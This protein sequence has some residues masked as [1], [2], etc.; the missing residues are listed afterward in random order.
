MK[1]SFLMICLILAALLAQY[2]TL[3][4][5]EACGVAERADILFLVD[6]SW[7][8]GESNFQ[9]IRDFIYD[10]IRT[11][12]NAMVGKGGVRLGVVLY[13]DKPRISIDLTDYITIEEVLVAVRD[14]VFKGGDG[15]TGSAFSFLLETM[16]ITGA[17]RGDAAKV[18]VLITDGKSSDSVEEAARLLKDAGVTVFTVGI[19]N[20]DRKELRKLASDPAEEHMLY[21][22]DFHQLGS[23]SRKLSRRLCITASE[24][25]RPAKPRAKVEKIVKPRDLI[26][27]E[28]SHNSLRLTWTPAT[29]KVTGYQVL[30][31]SFSTPGQAAP[32]D[33]RLIVL[34]ASKSTVLVTEL[35][36]NTKYFFTVLTVYADVL[37]EPATVKGKTTSIPPVTN[38]RVIEEGL[39]SLRVAWTPPLGKLEGYK[40]YIPKSNKTGMTSEK[41][42]GSDVSSHLLD[43]L[44]EDKDYTISI[45]A[46]YPEGPSQPVSTTGKTLKLLPVK[47]IWLQNETTNTIQARWTQVRG[48]SGYRLTWVSSEGSVQ[49]VNLG[50]TYSYYMIQGLQPGTEYTITVNPIFG[51]TEGPIVT[52]KATTLSSSAV[53]ILKAT[54]ITINSAVVFWNSVPGATGYRMT[55]GPTPEF[56]GQDR[57]RQLALNSSTTAYHLQNL[58]HNTEYVISL[59]VLFGSVEGPGITITARTSPLGSVSNFKVTSYTS[60]SI[61]LSWSTVPAA[62]K[63]KIIWKP[64]GTG[65]ERETAK[66]LLL[67]SHLRAHHLENLL[68]NTR[69]AIGIRAVFGTTEGKVVTLTQ[70]TVGSLANLS[71]PVLTVTS[72]KPVTMRHQPMTSSQLTSP[73]TTSLGP[74]FTAAHTARVP[75]TSVPSAT[76]PGP[77]CSKFKADIAFLVDESSSIGQSNFLKVKEFLFRI[78]S[79][80]PKI[81]PEGTQIAVA[82]YSE[83]PR[84]E[85]HFNRYQDRNSVLKAI[86]RLRYAGGDTKTGRGIGYMLKEVF[87]ASKGMRP[88]VPHTLVLLTDGRSQD[89]VLPPAQVA[90][91]IGIRLITVGVSGADPQELK[92]ILLHRNLENLF[93]VSTFDDLPQIIR[94]LI[95]TICIGSQQENVVTQHN[96]LVDKEGEM[97]KSELLLKKK[98]E[99]P[100]SSPSSVPLVVHPPEGPCDLKCPKAQ[101]GEKGDRGPPGDASLAGLHMGG[102]YDPFSFATKGE[103]GERGLPGKDGIPGLPG[104]PGRTGS[105]GSPGLMGLPGIQGDH[106]PPGY[107][108]PPG[109]KG[110]RGEPGYVLGGVEVIPGQNGQPGPPGYKGQPGVPGVPGPPGLPGLPG[111]QGPPGLSVKGELG[112]PGIRGPRGKNGLKGEKGEPGE[113]GKAGLPGPIGLDGTPGASGSKGEKGE[114][115]VGVP[116]L[117]GLKGAEGNKGVTGPPGSQGQKGE[118]GMPGPEGPT[119]LRGKKGQDGVKGEKG[120]RGAAGMKGLQGIAGLPGP[121]GPKGDQGIQGFPG[122]PAMGVVGPTGKKGSRGD[123]GAVGPSGPKGESGKQGEKGEKGSPGFG[124]PGQLGLKGEPGERGNV[125]LSGKPGQKGEI[126]PKGNKGEPGE[127]GNAGEPGLRGKDGEAGVPGEQGERGVR[128]PS[129][130]PGRP[131]ERG[132]QGDAGEPGKEGAAGEKGDKGESGQPGPPGLPGETVLPLKNSITIKGEKG[133][134]GLPGKGMNIKDLESL[135]EAYGIKLALLKDLTDLLLQEGVET[136]TQQ[137]AAS[138]KGKG[139]ASRRKQGPKQL[140]EQVTSVKCDVPSVTPASTT[141][142]PREDF[143][144]NPEYP[145]PEAVETLLTSSTLP[146]STIEKTAT[147]QTF[148][149]TINSHSGVSEITSH[150]NLGLMETMKTTEYP[151]GENTTEEENILLQRGVAENATLESQ[152]GVFSPEELSIRKEVEGELE[153]SPILLDLESQF[154]TLE[155]TSL[156]MIENAKIRKTDEDPLTMPPILEPEVEDSSSEHASKEVLGP[157]KKR[158]GER[159]KE[160]EAS[161]VTKEESTGAFANG[162]ETSSLR[163]RRMVEN[164]NLTVRSPGA[165][166]LGDTMMGYHARN[167]AYPGPHRTRRIKKQESETVAGE[168]G[169]NKGQKGEKGSPGSPGSK[170]EKGQPGE[171]GEP[172]EK[173]NKGDE[174]DVGQKGEPGMASVGQWAKLDLQGKSFQDFLKRKR[175]MVKLFALANEDEGEPGALGAPGAQGIQGIRGNP[176]IPRIPGGKRH[177]GLPGIPGQ[178]GAYGKRGRNGVAG[179]P[180]PLGPPG[181]EGML[182]AP[183]IK[184]NKGD[185][186]LGKLG[187]RGPRGFPGPRG[188]EGIV[189]VRGPVGMMGQ[190]GLVGLKGEKGDVGFPGPKGERGDPMTIFGP[191]GYKG[192][193]GD[194][195]ERGPPGFDGDK[196]EKGEDGPAGEKGVK[197]EAGSK[198]VMGLFGTRGPVGQ[199]GEIGEPGLPGFAGRAGL[200]GKNGMKGAKGDRGLQGQKGEPGGKGD[201]GITG[202]IGRKGSK[203]LRGLPGKTGPPGTHGIKGETGGTGRPGTPGADGLL[204]PKGDRGESGTDGLQGIM[205]QK[206]EKGSKGVPGLGGFKGQIGL[207]GKVGV[208][209]PPGPQGPQGDPGPQGE[210]G[211]RGRQQ[212]CLRGAPG[213]PGNKGGKGEE[214]PAGRKGERGDPGLSAEEVKDIVR[215]EMKDQEACADK[216]FRPANGLAD[217]GAD[218]LADVEPREKRTLLPKALTEQEFFRDVHNRTKADLHLTESVP[219]LADPC[220]LPMDEG[221]CKQYTVLWYYHQEANNCR[222]FIFGGCGG[223]AN[224]FPSKQT[225]EL[226]CKRATDQAQDA[227][228]IQGER[229]NEKKQKSAIS[230]TIHSAD[231]IV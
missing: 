162:K 5:Q 91:A 222:P 18:V 24:P 209:G 170:G 94:E 224:Q 129:G 159:K 64:A 141:D 47:T 133:E 59:Y 158:R 55:W 40:I 88:S 44:K 72:A 180:G 228:Q 7:S 84:T 143:S 119:G 154:H 43:N 185:T 226:W 21:A 35:K 9:W 216:N 63:Y 71:I 68:P 192:N 3:A 14:L 116:G 196:G 181:Q 52:A 117:P 49:N 174:G 139:K 123:I 230:K 96:K 211:R 193:K 36:P 29:G 93:Y 51:A 19:N 136:V 10:V 186:G 155:N 41:I 27:S 122:A 20:A 120:E 146:P 208:I 163:V 128:G 218:Y 220:V 60:T 121:V 176:G 78:V 2:K 215:T 48:A 15:G 97:D 135:F 173:G 58:A 202:D 12:E 70:G 46:V 81:G 28:Q 79:Y 169:P 134:P 83:E 137:I 198:G 126:G 92:K 144:L 104:R 166:G 164:R 69:Y 199:K 112:D 152:E 229:E 26:V 191:Q 221:A 76:T 175:R 17:L 56:F 98:G 90:H 172:G 108:G 161:Q 200:D 217:L 203:G 210:R 190:I 148:A 25:P 182:G 145:V 74:R 214:G 16:I 213:T 53:Q 113:T 103:K 23:L 102:G 6:E 124:I 212:L 30:F 33:Q 183:G 227:D 197:G 32:E 45:Y 105:P 65:Q 75:K 86:K 223:N 142:F 95:E 179:P 57:P 125:G 132:M 131:G 151:E 109:Q 54:D 39:S 156:Q 167:G 118:R 1:T 130:L 115:G 160:K 11:F 206:G 165:L 73:V 147:E 153:L 157:M 4:L 187:P 225:C 85:F 189:G 168:F 231:G 184:G 50:E 87:Q 82:Q 188:E 62:T 140:A 13:G 149:T 99:L 177:P 205:G 61:S 207:P 178:K 127:P 77:I 67:D 194:P 201:P 38:F 150:I 100:S 195:G 8:I 31:D 22:Q 114:I 111:P 37:G 110:D 106:G 42:L 138:K 171:A 66:S 219:P 34:D 101:K 89:D 204:G 107:P 80:F